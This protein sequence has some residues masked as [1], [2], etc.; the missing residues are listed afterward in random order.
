MTLIALVTLIAFMALVTRVVAAP[1]VKALRAALVA[2]SIE[3]IAVAALI[4]L[5]YTI[6]AHAAVVTVPICMLDRIFHAAVWTV[7]IHTALILTLLAAPIAV[8]TAT[9]IAVLEDRAFVA[10]FIDVFITIFI[11]RFLHIA[12]VALALVAMLLAIFIIA[13][14][15]MIT[16]GAR[17]LTFAIMVAI[18][19]VLV[20]IPF[21]IAC[22]LLRS[23]SHTGLGNSNAYD[24]CH[25]K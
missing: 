23:A 10:A 25:C 9:S 11:A 18:V 17:A 2:V 20:L 1:G 22:F 6:A 8:D 15:S 19:T 16:L 5:F 4:A 7:L 3:V 13:F 21:I 12:L 14:R 24:E